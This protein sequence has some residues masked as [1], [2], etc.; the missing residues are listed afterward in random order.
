MHKN[1]Y[2]GG[3]YTIDPHVRTSAEWK[4]NPKEDEFEEVEKQK[5]QNKN[6]IEVT[7]K[8]IPMPKTLPL[9]PQGWLK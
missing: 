3:K 2:R 1:Y 8:V 5:D 7:Q 9:F 6:E 4:K